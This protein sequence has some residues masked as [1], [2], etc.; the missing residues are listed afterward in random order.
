[1]LRLAGASKTLTGQNESESETV[2]KAKT[3]AAEHMHKK[4]FLLSQQLVDVKKELTSC[5][6]SRDR[7][8]AAVTRLTGQ[9]NQ[10]IVDLEKRTKA[11]VTNY[12]EKCEETK[13]VS[14]ELSS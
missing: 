1:L 9:L 12:N 8:M 13:Q 5:R 4:M 7:E 11:V 14:H 3:E 2:V 6:G 10:R